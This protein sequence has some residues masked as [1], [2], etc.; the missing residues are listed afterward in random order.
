MKKS[1]SIPGFKA[2]SVTSGIKSKNQKDLALVVAENP[3]TCAGVFTTNIAKAA[4]VLYSQ[5]IIQ[6][7][8]AQAVVANSGSAN[9]GTGEKGQRDV[10]KIV[11]FAGKLLR[12]SP[13]LILAAS[14]GKI[15]TPLPV[16]KIKAGLKKA[17]KKLAAAGWSQAASG[18]LTTDTRAKISY[19][20]INLSYGK[21]KIGAIAKG[22]GMICPNLATMLVFIATDLKTSAK[23]LAKLLKTAAAESFNCLSVDACMSTNDTVFLLASGKNQKKELSENSADFSR[24]Q[25]ALTELCQDLCR[26]IASDGEGATKL[27]EVEVNR[28]ASKEAAKILARAVV[29]SDL[30]KTAIFGQDPNWGRILAALGAAGPKF[31]PDKIEIYFGPHQI[32]V[33]GR[34]PQFKKGLVKKYLFR[35]NIKITINLNQGK[36]SAL[37]FGCDLSYDYVKINAHYN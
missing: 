27:I 15:G 2:S 23:T 25:K 26:Q 11:G 28:A 8:R 29:S 13:N 18:I 24:F 4:P 14:T 32:V 19:Q 35:K 20:E 36:F 9:A 16:E 17:Q 7:G 21:V 37:A 5:K 12:I 33:S 22:S 31:N 30:V 1:F 10:L 3:G 6:S 34:A